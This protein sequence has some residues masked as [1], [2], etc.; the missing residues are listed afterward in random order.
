[1]TFVD[2]VRANIQARGFTKAFTQACLADIEESCEAMW[3]W[4]VAETADMIVRAARFA[5]QSHERWGDGRI[6]SGPQR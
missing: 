5:N 1:M 2:N 4:S 3:G 6:V